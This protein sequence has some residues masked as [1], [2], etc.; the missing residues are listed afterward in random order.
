MIDPCNTMQYPNVSANC[1]VN[2]ASE[3]QVSFHQLTQ[4]DVLFVGCSL[5]LYNVKP[6]RKLSWFITPK[7]MV[8]GTY[9]YSYWGL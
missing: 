4:F 1:C 8:Y 5:S 3:T 6:P 9:G 7:T 2:Y